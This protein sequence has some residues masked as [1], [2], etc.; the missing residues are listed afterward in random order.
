M[1]LRCPE[2][3]RFRSAE[4]FEVE[5]VE[6]DEVEIR[7]ETEVW[8]AITG[9]ITVQCPECGATIGRFEFQS[10]EVKL[11]KKEDIEQED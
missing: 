4:E 10:V 2:C 1:P 11:G 3:H 7:E 8:G 9:T 5:D 6:L